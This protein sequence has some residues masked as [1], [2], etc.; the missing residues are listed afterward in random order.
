MAA[1]VGDWRVVYEPQ[2][3]ALVVLVLTLG[4]R[5]EIYDRL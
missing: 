5:R 4:H 2:D 1:K 3:D